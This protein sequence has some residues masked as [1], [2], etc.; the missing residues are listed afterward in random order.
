MHRDAHT[1]KCTVLSTNLHTPS[2]HTRIYT[3]S[4]HHH[5]DTNYIARSANMSPRLTLCITVH[6]ALGDTKCPWPTLGD[7]SVGSPWVPALRPRQQSHRYGQS[8]CGQ[9]QCG[10]RAPQHIPQR[11]LS[12]AMKQTRSSTTAGQAG[13]IGYKAI[14]K[15]LARNFSSPFPPTQGAAPSAPF[16]RG[17]IR[18]ADDKAAFKQLVK[19][20]TSERS[21][22]V[23]SLCIHN[24]SLSSSLINSLASERRG[25]ESV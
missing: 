21:V 6:P 1:R 10:C 17:R 20:G 15:L 14:S 16:L 9:R 12:R 3:H 25:H 13:G 7:S 24:F 23:S 18:T 11:A 4:Q 22:S 19:Q 2:A 8:K 5:S